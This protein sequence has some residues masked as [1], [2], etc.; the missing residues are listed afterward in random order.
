M[1]IY[2]EDIVAVELQSGTIQR[3]FLNN[4]IGSGDKKANRFGVRLFRNGAPVSAESCTVT[5]I[6]M[7]PDGTRYVIS[8]TS[9]TGSTGKEGNK[10]W[11]QLPEI[12]YAV[13]GQFCLA[14][15]LTGGGVDGTM[16][17]IDGTVSE[18]G[19][20]GAVVPT[21][22]IPTTEEIIAAYEEAVDVIGGSVRFDTEQSL[23][24]AEKATA[25]ENI[26]A[27]ASNKAF[28]SHTNL[29]SNDDIDNVIAIGTY[30]K[31]NV[32]TPAHWPF[33]SDHAGRLNVFSQSETGANIYAF[34]QVAF[35]TTSQEM[36]FRTGNSASAW[37]AWK[38][39][40]TSGQAFQSWAN[41]S[42]SD[43]IDN[44]IA[45][46]TYA[47]SNVATPEHWP[48][49]SNHAGRLN[50]F[51]ANNT[52]TN[53]YAF[54]Q[55]AYDITSQEMAFRTG[56]SASAWSAWKYL[57]TSSQN[58]WIAPDSVIA[59]MGDSTSTYTGYSESH[60]DTVTIDEVTYPYRGTYYP[61][62]NVDKVS[63]MWWDIVL[64][65]I[66]TENPI[67]LSS[68]S[69]SSY[70][71]NA[72]YDG[73]GIPAPWHPDRI[74]RIVNGSPDYVFLN[75]GINDIF[76]WND[77]YDAVIPTTEDISALD[78]LHDGTGV[79]AARTIRKLIHAMPNVKI[80]GIIPKYPTVDAQYYTP[81]CKVCDTLEKVFKQYGVWK[82]I[83]LRRCG[84]NVD[85]TVSLAVD[86][87]GTHP[88]VSG[89][90]K[91]ADYIISQIK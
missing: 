5:G 18:T 15:K 58:T 81:Y 55:V 83:D 32:A 86:S 71:R 42:S 25:L 64:T 4:T 49:A 26:G 34:V 53:I 35:D 27:I 21:S 19:E 37:S 68:V 44:V 85:N 30:A 45:I 7:A 91:I 46:G 79:G 10:A 22:T 3:S 74:A 78:A 8:E 16:R 14:I 70:R 72:T 54:V 59:V 62:G 13:T 17:I 40:Q 50:V 67:V 9:Y 41:L 24:D 38:Y 75:L 47:K 6:F 69:R 36:A 66:G 87:G 63:E 23:T 39:L 77:T 48:F 76:S 12:C 57:L 84:I 11:V 33:A 82:I 89:M 1:A 43:D 61:S 20:A 51:S 88:N 90:A 80:I 28:R 60:S 56:N 73:D 52:G 29:S 31:S 2:K 65:A